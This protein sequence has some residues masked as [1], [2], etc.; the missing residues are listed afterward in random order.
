MPFRV[1]SYWFPI[2]LVAGFISGCGDSGIPRQAVHG[3]I[4]GAEG[5]SGLVNFVP[6]ENT[7]GPAARTSLIDGEYQFSRANGPVPGDYTV[8]IQLE[9]SQNMTSGVVVFK[10]IEIPENSGAKIPPAYEA[11]ATFPASV[12]DGS[13]TPLQ[14]D[15][16]LPET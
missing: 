6:R 5:R 10:G 16:E 12:P 14:V 8:I 3:R 13:Q 1:T 9:V 15:L 4:S 11:V 7:R 2:F